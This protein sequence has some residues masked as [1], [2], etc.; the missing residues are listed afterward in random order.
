MYGTDDNLYLQL[1]RLRHHGR[2]VG[3]STSWQRATTLLVWVV[4]V[5]A[6]TPE[7]LDL[8]RQ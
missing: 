5:A 1:F 6:S 2:T 4:L 8:S 3:T 7:G